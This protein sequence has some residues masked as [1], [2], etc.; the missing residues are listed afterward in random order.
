MWIEGSMLELI[1][2]QPHLTFHACYRFCCLWDY[3]F[4]KTAWHDETSQ[5]HFSHHHKT[6]SEIAVLCAKIILFY[7]S[8]FS[9][10]SF[11]R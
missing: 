4:D 1:T 8:L 2:A 7:F 5:P 11:F 3:C 10:F 9:H 6:S